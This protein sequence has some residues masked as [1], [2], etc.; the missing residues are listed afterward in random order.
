[1][2]LQALHELLRRSA[3]NLG[4][5]GIYEEVDIMRSSM[6]DTEKK[7]HVCSLTM[8]PQVFV[9]R[10]ESNFR[11]QKS[12]QVSTHREHDKECIDSED[13]SRTTRYP[14]TEF[15]GVQ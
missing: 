15:K 9:E 12:N 1:M 6:N 5:K 11:S 3:I 2:L 8:K 14:Y 7:K 10:E 4:L 13:K